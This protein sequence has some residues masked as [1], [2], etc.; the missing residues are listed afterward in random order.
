MEDIL[1][2]IIDKSIGELLIPSLKGQTEQIQT[3]IKQVGKL[4]AQVG[5]LTAQVEE[6]KDKNITV[7]IDGSELSI[8]EDENENENENDSIFEKLQLEED[9]SSADEDEPSLVE[10]SLDE[11]SLVET[12]LDELSLVETSLVETSLD[13]PSLVETS[14]EETSL[15]ETSLEESSVGEKDVSKI[16]TE[17]IS[18]LE[19][20]K[21]KEYDYSQGGGSASSETV[22][23]EPSI[24]FEDIKTLAEI[25]GSSPKDSDSS[26]QLSD[27]VE[28]PI[29]KIDIHYSVE[30]LMD[31]FSRDGTHISNYHDFYILK[32]KICLEIK[33]QIHDCIT[34]ITQK[35][36]NNFR[37]YNPKF[38][39]N[40]KINPGKFPEKQ[41]CSGFTIEGE[42]EYDFLLRKYILM[43]LQNIYD[44]KHSTKNIHT[45]EE[46]ISPY[47][48]FYHYDMFEFMI[49]YNLIKII[50]VNNNIILSPVLIE[51]SKTLINIILTV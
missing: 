9:A 1:K 8:I 50:K 11:P 33:V 48:N 20:S 36:E 18:Q 23:I 45:E 34:Q 22:T 12:S 43:T 42:S 30:E 4:T 13:E 19:K 27:I 7:A 21:V 41:E 26:I 25:V 46:Y 3:L 5:K 31:Y 44:F 17:L 37:Y 51:K 6:L 40:E 2:T 32:N 15:V 28:K 16:T 49:K 47:Y 24:N 29:Q 39:Y 35:I 10:T 14:V 38:K